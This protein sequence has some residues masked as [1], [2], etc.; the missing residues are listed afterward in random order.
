MAEDLD[1][2]NLNAIKVLKEILE[3]VFNMVGGFAVIIRDV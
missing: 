3:N 1:A 2:M